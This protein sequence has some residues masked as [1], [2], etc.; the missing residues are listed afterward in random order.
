MLEKNIIYLKK[1]HPYCTEMSLDV[2]A[3]IHNKEIVP[4][5]RIMKG[6]RHSDDGEDE[7]AS[8][9]QGIT[10]TCLNNTV[11]EDNAKTQEMISD[12]A[13]DQS[14]KSKL[15]YKIK[16]CQV[17]GKKTFKFIKMKTKSSAEEW[18]KDAEIMKRFWKSLNLKNL[19]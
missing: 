9:S 10:P 11:K 17:G 19:F 7:S 16:I 12:M 2:E 13:D 5:V 8:C 4:L 3:G 14:V 6:D 15:K 1:Y 18:A